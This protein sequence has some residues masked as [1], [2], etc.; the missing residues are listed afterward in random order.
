[1]S[2][3]DRAVVAGSETRQGWW[4]V[5]A[6]YVVLFAVLGVP[7]LMMPVMYGAIIDE[8]GWSRGEVATI[9]SIKYAA[10]ALAAFFA[11]YVV[12]RFGVKQVTILCA[13]MTGLTM[14]S[15][16]MIQSLWAFYVMG[17]TLGLSALGISVAMKILISQWFSNRQGVAI[18]IAMLGIS[19]AGVVTPILAEYLIGLYGWRNAVMLLSLGI[20]LVALP[21]FMIKARNAAAVADSAATADRAVQEDADSVDPRSAS[22]VLG[23]VYKDVRSSLPFWMM[24]IGVAFIGL[25][26]QALSQHM[27]LYLDRDLNMGSQIAAIGFSLTMVMS[28]LGKIGFGYLFDKI[29]VNGVLICWLVVTLSVGLIFPVV[30]MLTLILFIVV[31]GTSEGGILISV[32]VLCK[33]CFGN[34][35]LSQTISVMTASYMLGGAFGTAAVGYLY[36]ITGSYTMPF[37]ILFALALV[38]SILLL[39]LKPLY[40]PAVATAG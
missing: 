6:A 32:P 2:V 3:S 29:S 34:R 21:F 10:G 24:L 40:R 36:D 15:V 12:D 8:T 35:S 18:A 16:S 25:V 9:G 37:A 13:L 31:R 11:G 26:D 20:W 30:G 19:T 5:A 28:N 23:P 38:A 4:N 7:A 14:L 39:W 17:L 33:H 22:S 1:M 27:V